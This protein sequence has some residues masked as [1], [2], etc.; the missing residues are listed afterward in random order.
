MQ[1]ASFSAALSYLPAREQERIRKAFEQGAKMHEGQKRRSGEPYF[2]HPVAVAVI[3]AEMR[4]DSDTLIAALLHDTVE[5]TDLTLDEIDQQYNGAVRSLIDGVTKL[6]SQDIDGKPTMDEQIET[7]RKIFTLMQQDVRIM[8]IKLVDRLH[9][10]RTVK[11]LTPERQRL[12]AKETADV[13]VKIADRLS[14]QDLRNELER[15]T[16]EVLEPELFARLLD[17]RTRSD[18]QADHAASA[19]QTEFLHSSMPRNVRIH[20]ESKQWSDLREQLDLEHSSV[21]GLADIVIAFECSSIA[22]CY[23]VLGALHQR[24]RRETMSF[25]DF[26]NSPKINGY[27]GLHTTIIFPN[28]LRMRCK[29]RTRDMQIYAHRGISSMCFDNKAKGLLEY[30]PWAQHIQSLSD[31]TA[32]RSEEFWENL[33]SDI[34]GE[35]IVVHGTGDNTV[36]LPAGSTALDGAFYCFHDKALR[37]KS[38]RVN[39]QYVPFSTPLTHSVSLDVELSARSTVQREWLD[40]VHTGVATAMIRSALSNQS[41]HHKQ[42]MGKEILQKRM[43]ERH[44]GYLEEFDRKT[45][46]LELKKMGYESLDSTYEAIA[47]GHLKAFDVVEK[48]FVEKKHTNR[49]LPPK[50]DRSVIQ[51]SLPKDD[52]SLIRKVLDIYE[53]HNISFR[54]IRMFTLPGS[55]FMQFSVVTTMNMVESDRFKRELQSIGIKNA[56]SVIRNRREIL[57]MIIVIILWGLNPV[58]SRLLLEQGMT[59]LA[60]ITYRLVIF[61]IFSMSFFAVWRIVTKVKLTP[62]PDRARLSLLPTLGHVGMSFY[63]FALQ[64]IPPSVHLTLLRFNTIIL[65]LLAGAQKSAKRTRMIFFSFA[66]LATCSTFFW[67]DLGIMTSVGL[68]FSLMALFFYTFYSLTLERAL[69]TNK[70]DVRHPAM[71]F[72]IGLMSGVIGLL[73]IPLQPMSSL[74]NAVSI[75]ALLYVLFCVCI[76]GACYSALLKTAKFKHVTDFFLLEIPIAL[77]GEYALLGIHLSLLSY[78]VITMTIGMLIG[79]RWK[80]RMTS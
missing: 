48:L 39:G 5:D 57:L 20:A 1:W 74:I 51:F 73:L 40:W 54:K 59:P 12:L 21:T 69:Q 50:Q 38:I 53:R 52:V 71:M 33:K 10:M 66:L 63:Y 3:L 72:E 7:L 34:L 2:T 80:W 45:I 78:L 6:S 16:L 27:Q 47:E 42:I 77:V 55:T 43:T 36:L 60:L 28:G 29:I 70:I 15:L 37:V 24:W 32:N 14:M 67:F 30:L 22:A 62:I 11:F 56:E 58:L 26:I 17:M 9:N 18:K 13:Y 35:S 61:G 44:L 49:F 65:P 31:D 23:E 79:L 19:M 41:K 4:A 68:L 25:Q 75:Y 64:T 46:L 8:I 76:A